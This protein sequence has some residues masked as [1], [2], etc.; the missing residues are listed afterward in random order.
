ML[1]G[2]IFLTWKTGHGT[3]LKTHT[4]RH[5]KHIEKNE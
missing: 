2:I 4:H 3:K 5:T 1:K